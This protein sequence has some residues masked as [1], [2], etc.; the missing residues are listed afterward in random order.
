MLTQRMRTIAEDY[1]RDPDEVA[2]TRGDVWHAAM[3]S[4]KAL[5]AAHQEP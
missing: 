1:Q 4:L 5:L 3:V 2:R